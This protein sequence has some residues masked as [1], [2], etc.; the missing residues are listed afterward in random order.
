MRRKLHAFILILTACCLLSPVT[1]PAR[2]GQDEKSRE[3]REEKSREEKSRAARGG[4]TRQ[5]K[6]SV[7]GIRIGSSLEDVHRRLKSL[8]TVGGR[9][10]RDGGR[11]E[12]CTLTKT[13]FSSVAY[14]T[15]KEGRVRWVTGFVRPG[16]E[17]PFSKLGDLAHASYKN[18]SQAIWNIE[19]AGGGYRL[20]VKGPDG[21][22]RVVSLLSLGEE[23]D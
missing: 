19:T 13:E 15:D 18:D 21:K 9:D 16:K 17:I 11:R 23:E 12:A 4:K 20:V 14:Q 22:A 7:L 8:G 5:S 3:E 6:T 1:R 10:T 2:A